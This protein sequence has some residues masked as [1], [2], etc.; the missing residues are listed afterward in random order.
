[1]ADSINIAE[2]RRSTTPDHRSARSFGADWRVLSQMK[3]APIDTRW[4]DVAQRDRVHAIEAICRGLPHVR[5]YPWPSGFAS[6][7]ALFG[8]DAETH[9]FGE[10]PHGWI[11][12][13]EP[14]ITKGF[15]HFLSS[16][17]PDR[18]RAR[19]LS[20]VKAA[21]ACSPC[22][23]SIKEAWRPV[24]ACAEAEEN[25]I[26]ILVELTDGQS[27]FGAA[28]EAKFGHHLTPGQLEAADR[29]VLDLDGRSWDPSRSAF[30]VIAPLLSQIDVE[31]LKPNPRWRPLSWWAFLTKLEQEI[32]GAQDCVDYRRFRRSVWYKAY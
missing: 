16:G 14:Q 30:L 15:V 13:L 19:C 9:C 20:F 22:S 10:T 2:Q 3:A 31:L 29:H 1:M 12:P 26:D 32:D 7:G 21:L 17:S 18:R 24:S 4:F 8:L 6:L 28:I 27:R 11:D 23:Q 25:R 5:P